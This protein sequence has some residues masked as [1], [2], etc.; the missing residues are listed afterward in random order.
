MSL[1]LYEVKAA[2]LAARNF[3]RARHEVYDGE[4]VDWEHWW[5]YP[6]R[7]GAA[8][9]VTDGHDYGGYRSAP[10][11]GWVHEPGCTCE[12]APRCMEGTRTHDRVVNV[13]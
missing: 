5:F 6:G 9:E 7:N 12:F 11:G 10:I 8:G 4:S 13:E 3:T 1:S 2:G